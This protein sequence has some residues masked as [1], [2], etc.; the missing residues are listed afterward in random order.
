MKFSR[1]AKT[2]S[3]AFLTVGLLASSGAAAGAASAGTVPS[4]IASVTD[5]GWG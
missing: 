1:L 4:V 2:V 3:A 5:T